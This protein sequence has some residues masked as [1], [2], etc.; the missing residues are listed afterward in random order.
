MVREDSKRLVKGAFLLTL[1]GLIGKL[2]G[3]SYRIPLQNLTGDVGFYIYQQIYPIL[4]LGLMLG[5]YGLPSGIARLRNE[6]YDEGKGLSIRSFYLPVWFILFI[7]TGLI[8][9]ILYICAPLL[10]NWI[11]DTQLTAIYQFGALAFLLIPFTA[12]LRGVFQGLYEMQPVAYSQMIEQLVR[13]SV[14]I[15][16][17]VVVSDDMSSRYEIGFGA[18]WAA[19][20]GGLFAV[21]VLLIFVLKQ[22]PYDHTRYSVEWRRYIRIVL[23]V[24]IIVTLNHALLLIFQIADSFTLLPSLLKSGL[25]QNDAMVA[26]G[27]FDRGQPLI[28]IGSI[29]GSSFAL[30]SIS[31]ISKQRLKQEPEV[32]GPYIN[33]T[34]KVSI[35]LSIGA[36]VGI[37]TLFPLVNLLLFQDNQGDM[38]LRI[39]ML[40]IGLS[41]IG[42]TALSILQGL[43]EM[44]RT[45]FYIVGAFIIKWLLNLLLVPRF[46]ISGGALATA[47]ALIFLLIIAYVK[48]W[49]ILKTLLII[50]RVRMRGAL[51]ASAGMF[52][53]LSIMA[54]IIPADM[55]ESRV[56]YAIYV[57]G[58]V[59]TGAYAFIIILLKSHAFSDEEIT[60]LPFGSILKRLKG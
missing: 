43:G 13:V 22:R 25:T 57:L 38:S 33:A 2:L 19:I 49:R 58:L 40:S 54:T 60:I 45:A 55:I 17:A 37:I 29:I 1:A 52:I 30:A 51:L 15:I 46:G 11:G 47:G 24:G 6:L 50:E 28:Q 36:T 26:K 48:L 4:G 3:A 10:S 7:F 42:M 35:Y 39:L 56:L 41:A 31:A 20:L 14:V 59:I 27:V 12:L 9:I 34:L 44:R 21:I 32:Y 8:A 53:Y 23:F 5:L 18:V 16:V